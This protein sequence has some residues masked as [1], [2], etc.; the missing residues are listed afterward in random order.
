MG[1][2]APPP[3]RPREVDFRVGAQTGFEVAVIRYGDWEEIGILVSARPGIGMEA[4]LTPRQAEQL[5]GHL[6]EQLRPDPRQ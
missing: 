3:N 1:D 5:A 4:V 2:S 6:L